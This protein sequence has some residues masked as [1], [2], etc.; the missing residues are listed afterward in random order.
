MKRRLLWLVALLVAALG[1][2]P[3]PAEEAAEVEAVAAEAASGEAPEA[4]AEPAA[5][6]APAEPAEAPAETAETV[7]P[8]AERPKG[9]TFDAATGAI[10]KQL[11]DAVEQLDALRDRIADEKVP[12]ARRLN[13]LETELIQVRRAYQEATRTLDNRTLDLSTLARSIETLQQQDAYLSNLLGEYVRN[14]ES[15]MH[16]AEQHRYEDV[17]SEAKL[18]LENKNLSQ[19]KK[20]EAQAALVTT[21]LDRLKD[22]LGGTRFEGEAVDPDGTVREGTFAVLGPTALFLSSDGAAVGTAAQRLNST[23]PTIL[24]FAE[25]DD[26]LA[27]R[28]VVSTGTGRFPFDPTLGDAH[29]IEATRES[30]TEHIRK[31]GPVMVPILGMAGLALLIALYKWLRLA[32]LRSPSRKR[33]QA[34]LEAVARHDVAGAKAEAQRIGG[35]VGQMLRVGVAHLQEPRELIEEVMYEEVL[36][37]RLKLQRLLPFIAISAS[38][39][40]LLGLLGTVTGIINT[41]KLMTAFGAGDPQA[42]SGGISEA[43][44]TTEF[45]LIVA[46]PS[47]LLYAFLSRRARGIINRMEQAAVALVNTVGKHPFE[48]SYAASSLAGAVP[49]EEAPAGADA[50]GARDAEPA[51]RSDLPGFLLGTVLLGA[52]GAAPLVLQHVGGIGYLDALP[53]TLGAAAAVLIGRRADGRVCGWRAVPALAAA[54]GG[55]YYYA[56]QTLD[57]MVW[58]RAVLGGLAAVYVC[59][60]L[61]LGLG[62]LFRK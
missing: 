1:A 13:D 42:L 39:A 17:V 31:G 62:R 44:I 4:P 32:L 35:P 33:I 7:E 6:A 3:A 29:K 57:D 22:A 30:L 56:T 5:P 9:P 18:A 54:V 15:Q 47:L 21:S 48:R 8:E 14:F 16:I 25:A 51:A 43:L 55:A 50:A 36:S 53:W 59:G 28:Q 58:L 60:Y 34:M 12:L 37:T 61:G 41:F 26:A 40:P 11:R 27:A 10:M 52:L 49:G 46:I 38:A 2:A 20:Y 45:G 24:P 23:E 19:K